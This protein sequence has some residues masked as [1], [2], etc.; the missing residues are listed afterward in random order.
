MVGITLVS[1]GLPNFNVYDVRLPCERMGLCYPD[2]HMWQLMNT[3]EYR[4]VMN[5]PKK[6]EDLWEECSAMPH[7]A[8]TFD[9]DSSLGYYLAPL[10]DSGVPVLIY[11]GDQDYICNW[12]GGS[13]WTDALVWDGQ[14]EFNM[15]ET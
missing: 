15:S 12:V 3:L 2:D 1:P 9:H 11:N 10:L 8:L 14:K 13:Y 7:L 6:Q 4:D 5:I